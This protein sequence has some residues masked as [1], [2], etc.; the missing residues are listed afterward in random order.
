MLR[1]EQTKDLALVA[2]IFTH[3]SIYP[4]LCDDF[5]PPPEHFWPNDSPTVAYLLV[6]DG[7]ELLGM[8]M[9][10]PINGILWEVHHALLPHCWG[11]RARAAGREYLRW[12]WSNTQ[13][14][15]VIGFV[16]SQ[17]QL[18]IRYAKGLGLV[19]LGRI[20]RAYM[21]GGE[22]L[23]L[24]IVGTDRPRALSIAFEAALAA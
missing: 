20:D 8:F 1:L 19:E 9:T 12:L 21:R 5:Y 4:C 16:P 3:P 18:A 15:K 7:D 2:K 23:D 11:R 17:N 10:H 24:V 6:Y 13:A 22:L 14:L